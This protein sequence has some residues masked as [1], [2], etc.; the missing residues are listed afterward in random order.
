MGNHLEIPLYLGA[1]FVLLLLL[2]AVMP[3]AFPHFWEK[4]RNKTLIAALVSLPIFIP[5]N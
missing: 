2:I 3:L 5:A 4:N 1:P